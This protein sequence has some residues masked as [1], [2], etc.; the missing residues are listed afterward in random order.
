MIKIVI[1]CEESVCVHVFT[2]TLVLVIQ[3]DNYIFSYYCLYLFFSE[4]LDF[5]D[6]S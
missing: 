6:C 1:L 5:N 2:F 4:V 3:I